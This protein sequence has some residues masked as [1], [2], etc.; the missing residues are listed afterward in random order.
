MA[1][2]HFRIKSDKKSDGS[3][4]SVVQYVDYIQR[5]GRFKNVDQ[6]QANNNFIGNFI[7]STE[8]KDALAV[9]M[10]S[11]TKLT[12]SAL[13]EI[14]LK[15]LKSLKMLLRLLYPSLLCSVQ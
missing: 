4:V 10:L 12:T 3:K 1:L 7:S 2:F 5:K 8:T 6:I 9:V 11:S 14:L 13:S 15:A